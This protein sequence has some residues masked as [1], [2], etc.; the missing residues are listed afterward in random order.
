MGS[1]TYGTPM[2]TNKSEIDLCLILLWP[3]DISYYL[4][5]TRVIYC[6]VLV[7]GLVRRIVISRNINQY[8]EE[9]YETEL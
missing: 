8:K 3:S 4:D 6:P 2:R 9:G 7:G 5:F 1:L